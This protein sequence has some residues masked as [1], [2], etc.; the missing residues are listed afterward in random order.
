MI[1]GVRTRTV[2]IGN[3]LAAGFTGCTTV[4][5]AA[6]IRSPACAGLR[7][8]RCRPASSGPVAGRARPCAQV[9]KRLISSLMVCESGTVS[10]DAG[11]RIS[12]CPGRSPG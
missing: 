4:R 6:R 8:V 12:P 5:P 11:E 1:R 2:L 9:R 10:A 3:L 7:S